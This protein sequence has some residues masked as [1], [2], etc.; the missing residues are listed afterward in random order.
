MQCKS[1]SSEQRDVCLSFSLFILLRRRFFGFACAESSQQKTHDF[2]FKGLLAKNEGGPVDYNRAFKM[3]EVELAFMY[4]FFFTKRPAIYYGT[5]MISSVLSFVLIIVAP[6]IAVAAVTHDRRLAHVRNWSPVA[7]TTTA[8]R[9]ITVV[10]LACIVLLELVQTLHYWTTIWGRVYV[11]CH[12]T[13]GRRH[14][15]ALPKYATRIGENFFQICVHVLNKY[16]YRF[17]LKSK[18]YWQK[19]I[20]QYSLLESSGRSRPYFSRCS[21]VKPVKLIELPAEVTEALGLSLERT[22]GF[23][24]NGES[25]LLSNGAGDLLWACRQED[26]IHPAADSGT[27]SSQKK[28]KLQVF[29]LLT[30]HIATGYCEG[31]YLCSSVGGALKKKHHLVATTLSKYCAYLVVSAPKLLPGHHID[32]RLVFEAV[33]REAATGFL[34]SDEKDNND[35][36]MGSGLPESKSRETAEPKEKIFDKG[37]RLGKQLAGMEE[38]IRWKVL[39]DFWAEMLLYLAP[40]DNVKEHVECLTNGGELITHLWALLTHAGILERGQRNIVSNDMENAAGADQQ[41]SPQ[42]LPY[43]ASLRLWH[44]TSYL[45]KCGGG[46]AALATCATNKPATRGNRAQPAE[47][48]QQQ[49]NPVQN[50]EATSSAST[51]PCDIEEIE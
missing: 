16:Y 45:D 26:M 49:A 42:D 23:L 6:V 32:T 5:W 25:S 19:K 13:V 12:Q 46:G 18:C 41:P 2:V 10:I 47:M 51:A 29:V 22:Q 37:V 17:P 8:D 40:S 38:G 31:K 4:D 43:G 14:D 48:V 7:T 1:L 20:G 44:A 15:E 50:V 39:V 35:E 27:S 9:I 11:A 30:W 28:E 34:Q 24:T 36:A 21:L 33:A 3:I